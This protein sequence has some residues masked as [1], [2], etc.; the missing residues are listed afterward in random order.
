MPKT[1]SRAWIKLLSFCK[2]QQ[3]CK[4]VLS[5]IYEFDVRGHKNSP[6][7]QP[8]NTQTI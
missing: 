7:I 3:K 8:K 2:K 6:K 4:W 5:N 1:K